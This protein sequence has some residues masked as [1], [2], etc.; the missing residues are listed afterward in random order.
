MAYGF[1]NLSVFSDRYDPRL[2]VLQLLF[3]LGVVG[4]LVMLYSSYELWK[5]ARIRSW[6]TVYTAGLVLASSI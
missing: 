1:S 2:R 4:T 6:T 5:A 3:L